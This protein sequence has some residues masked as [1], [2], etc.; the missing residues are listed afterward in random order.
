MEPTFDVRCQTSINPILCRLRQFFGA[1]SQ[2]ITCLLLKG[3]VGFKEIVLVAVFSIEILLLMNS[4]V[5]ETPFEN[6][7]LEHGKD[8]AA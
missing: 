6:V 7:N 1:I 3:N 4:I 5:V 2:V 8:R